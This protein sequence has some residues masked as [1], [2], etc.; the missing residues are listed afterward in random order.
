VN[1]V[2]PNQDNR[3]THMNIS[4]MSLTA[5]APNKDNAIKLMEYLASDKAQRMY[6]EQNHE[7]PV[8]PEVSWS[9][10]VESWGGFKKDTTALAEIAKHRATASKMVDEIG[11][12]F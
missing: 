1:I 8:N 12:D 9:A 10:L 7:Y 5:S 2:F 6:A 3:G 11:Y 4:G